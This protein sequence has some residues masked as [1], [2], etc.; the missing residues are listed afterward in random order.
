MLIKDYDLSSEAVMELNH[1]TKQRRYYTEWKLK[2]QAIEREIRSIAL[3]DTKTEKAAVKVAYEIGMLVLV[4]DLTT[5]E[6]RTQTLIGE[7]DTRVAFIKTGAD[8]LRD[9]WT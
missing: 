1:E 2:L 3:L 7:I 6:E 5:S 9:Q 4:I 8:T